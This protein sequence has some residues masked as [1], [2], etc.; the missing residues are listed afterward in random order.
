MNAGND[1]F[2]RTVISD[3]LGRAAAARLQ[4]EARPEPARAGPARRILG[5]ARQL[6]RD[7]PHSAEPTC[8]AGARRG[9]GHS[10]SR[11]QST[12]G[13]GGLRA[14][15]STD[16][17]GVGGDGAYPRRPGVHP[18]KTQALRRCRARSLFELL[19]G[20]DAAAHLVT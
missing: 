7:R 10:A 3:P 20:N 15:L 4:D 17:S 14:R 16:T 13:G 6:Y 19:M 5:A 18:G 12:A 2:Y 11:A 8:A 1:L 9:T